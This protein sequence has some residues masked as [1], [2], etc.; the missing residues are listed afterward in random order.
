MKGFVRKVPKRANKEDFKF[1]DF[2]LF[3]PQVI[4]SDT[5]ST[6]IFWLIETGQKIKEFSRC[7]GNAEISTMTLDGTETRL[8]TGGMDGTVKV[9]VVRGVELL[10]KKIEVQCY[11][12]LGYTQSSEALPILTVSPRLL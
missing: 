5:G 10:G 12:I 4:S 7:H 2:F 6:I 11:H 8:F 1:G 3:L 9:C